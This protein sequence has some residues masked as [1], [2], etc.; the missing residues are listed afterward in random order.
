M[1]KMVERKIK[2]NRLT[3]HRYIKME[4]ILFFFISHFLLVYSIDEEFD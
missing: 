4:P 1:V 3:C 2:G